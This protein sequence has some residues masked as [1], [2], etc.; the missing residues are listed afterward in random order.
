MWERCSFDQVKF[1][2]H[3]EINFLMERKEIMFLE[4]P[5]DVSA[6]IRR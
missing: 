3:Y 5:N 2:F 6:L 4:K 1:G